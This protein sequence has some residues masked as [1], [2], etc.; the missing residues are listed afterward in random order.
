LKNNDKKIPLTEEE[1]EALIAFMLT[2]S[3]KA[4][5]GRK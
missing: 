1:K 2:L 3:D 4:F 5:V